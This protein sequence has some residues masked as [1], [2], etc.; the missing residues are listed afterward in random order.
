[1][2][3]LIL[4][5][6]A[7]MVWAGAMAVPAR[8]K[9]MTA[10]QSDGTTVTI[11]K[12]GDEWHHWTTTSDGYRVARVAN[13]DFHYVK[14][15]GRASAMMAH[16][17][18]L[19]TSNE[20]AFLNQTGTTFSSDKKKIRKAQVTSKLNGVRR[21]ASQVPN[22]GRPRVPIVLVE[23]SDIKF[24]RSDSEI[25]AYFE[26]QMNASGEG[27][28]SCYQYFVDQSS[29]RYT[30]Q[31][32]IL[33]PVQ[34]DARA[35]YGGN[36]SGGE[37]QALDAFVKD[38]VA[39]L[40]DVDWSV[41]DNDNDGEVDVVVFEY[42]GV[43]EASS[44]ED[45]SIWPCQWDMVSASTKWEWSDQLGDWVVTSEGEVLTLNSGM[46]IDKFAVFNEMNGYYDE[47]PG[48]IDGVGTFCHEYS[49][50]L[51]LPDFYCTDYSEHFGMGSW[52]CLDYGCNNNEGYTP[53][54]Y[55]A[56]EKWFMGWKDLEEAVPGTKYNLDA[57]NLATGKGIKVQSE[58]NPNEYY[59]LENRQQTGWDTYIPN[60]G[61]MVTHVLYNAARW[62]NNE[63]NNYDDKG[64]SIIP[65][66]NSLKMD[67][68]YDWESGRYYYYTN[69]DDQKG[70]LFPYKN[71]TE[72]T[73]EST[74]AAT[75]Y[76]GTG[77]MSKPITNIEDNDG[78]VSFNFMKEELPGPVLNDAT[79]VTSTGFTASWSEVEDALSYT[80]RVKYDDP[81]AAAVIL[82][83]DLT[84][85]SGE[86]GYD[87]GANNALDQIM[88]N[89]G[90]TGS[91]VYVEGGAV[92]L[93][94]SKADGSLVSPSLDTQ[95]RGQVSVE[96]TGYSYNVDGDITIT[97]STSK[98]STTVDLT[99]VSTTACVVLAAADNDKVTIRATQKKR[100]MI[101]NI[102]IYAGDANNEGPAPMLFTGI[103]GT[104]YTVTGLEPEATYLFDVKAIFA[105]D[106]TAWSQQKSVTLIDSGDPYD[107]NE[108]GQVNV[109]DVSE[110]Y[111]AIV[112]GN[113]SAK[114]DLNG[115]GQ[116]NV[117]DVTAL[118]KRLMQ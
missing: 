100:P 41:Y 35:T 114:Y 26:N 90:W 79:A 46:V 93:A 73:D 6:M 10:K 84:G 81:N 45:E 20:I 83:E 109:G 71:A 40:Q 32:D 1:M 38:A 2:K 60:H 82:T 117:G 34:I 58:S 95:G 39:Q 57:T 70:D 37:D 21:R 102:V 88:N 27:V 33:G 42:A 89:A 24:S 30:P 96:I 64:M 56:Y 94:A 99:D 92:R 36:D 7:L 85:V 14:A 48:D 69:L 50:C 104:S 13:G 105:D 97:V 63:V 12:H 106:E 76:T 113:T 49:H 68:E 44:Y 22:M 28:V 8:Q 103:E 74:P 62:A 75:L 61:L 80:L 18:A 98:A 91:K 17:V 53:C 51:G 116:V 59:I 87:Y 47:E 115:D 86:N 11:Q 19:R 110:L 78:I 65:A 9:L 77:F 112:A 23:F 54:G 107:L 118:Y 72:L 43:G 52:S 25:K 31:F 111:G 3:K 16:D 108:D 101:T 55:T 5:A 29:G 4:M 15:D 66:D 67:G